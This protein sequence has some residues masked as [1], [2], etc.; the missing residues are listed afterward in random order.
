MSSIPT[1]HTPKNL[2][3]T[4]G[5]G[6]IGSN[7]INY[8]FDKWSETKIINFDKIAFG[9]NEKHIEEEIKSSER[10]VFIK[11]TLCNQSSVESTLKKYNVRFFYIT[12]LNVYLYF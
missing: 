4:G 1:N 7:F 5:C 3:V 6:F 2:L 10:Y 9:A 8:I 11:D 12:T